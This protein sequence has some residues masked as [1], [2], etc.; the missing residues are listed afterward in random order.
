MASYTNL[1]FLVQSSQ[2]ELKSLLQGSL[3]SQVLSQVSQ[4]SLQPFLSRSL[5]SQK[6][7]EAVKPSF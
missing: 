6:A 1:A 4:E 5:W 3:K 7:G 2:R